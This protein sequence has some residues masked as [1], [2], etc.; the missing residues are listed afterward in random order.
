MAGADYYSCD[1]C[2]CKTF[3]DAN[4]DYDPPIEN[5]NPETEHAWPNGNVG[6]MAVICKECAK[7][8]VIQI[9]K[10]TA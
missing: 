6:D 10:R 4:L 2:G 1:V 9:D 7:T 8:H 3:Y 5:R